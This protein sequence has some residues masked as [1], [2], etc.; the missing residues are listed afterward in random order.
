MKLKTIVYLFSCCVLFSNCL[1][2]TQYQTGKTVGKNSAEIY[3]ADSGFGAEGYAVSPI[4][5]EGGINYGISDKFDLTGK[6]GVGG[7]GVGGKYQ[8]VGDIDSKFATSIAANISGL[9]AGGSFIYNLTIPIHFSFHPS[10]KFAFALSPSYNL[11]GSSTELSADD[12]FNT[13]GSLIGLAP[14][15]EFGRRI[16]FMLGAN[17]MLPLSDG[18]TS[19][20]Y[21]YGLGIKFKI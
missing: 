5:L 16:K 12:D 18:N 6:L 7:I 21:T 2:F 14:H 3:I 19:L 20:I 17:F 10:D 9:G 13:T 1:S 4:L 15:L 8:V 11:I